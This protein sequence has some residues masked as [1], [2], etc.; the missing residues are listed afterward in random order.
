MKEWIR[1]HTLTKTLVAFNDTEDFP[2]K[3]DEIYQRLDDDD[4]SGLVFEEFC[5]GLKNMHDPPTEETTFGIHRTPDFAQ[6]ELM[7][8]L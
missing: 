2:N 3:M 7:M 6:H 1:C 4:S 5:A 8:F